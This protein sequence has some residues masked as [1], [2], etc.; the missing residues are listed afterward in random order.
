MIYQRCD[1]WDCGWCYHPDLNL[2]NGCIG[3]DRCEKYDVKGI[4]RIDVIGQNGN[5]GEHY[6]EEDL[7]GR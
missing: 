7:D 3:S 4:S 6:E 5:S 1:Y 2:Q